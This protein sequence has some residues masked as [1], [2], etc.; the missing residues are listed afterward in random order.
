MN[1]KLSTIT[2]WTINGMECS[3]DTVSV[4]DLT[5]IYTGKDI[6]PGMRLYCFCTDIKKL[7]KNAF[8]VYELKSYLKVSL[9]KITSPVFTRLTPLTNES[10]AAIDNNIPAIGFICSD[11]YHVADIP[12]ANSLS[13]PGVLI[14]KA[15]N[16][17]LAN[18]VSILINTLKAKITKLE[19]T[20][21][22]VQ[23]IK[24]ETLIKDET[25]EIGK[26]YP[27]QLDYYPE[28]NVVVEINGINYNEDD[29]SDFLIEKDEE[30]KR[31]IIY[32]DSDDDD[33]TI[34]DLKKTTDIVRI[35]YKATIQQ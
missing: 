18:D 29:S 17:N 28:S 11:E 12:D 10:G 31:A 2:N 14:A 22:Y 8:V 4:V 21:D 6:K 35:K 1:I 15:R 25:A 16:Y 24:T 13:L 32:F 23:P 7:T 5:N 9:S 30:N 19:N 33:F 3:A 27:V 26:Q 20:V 34:E